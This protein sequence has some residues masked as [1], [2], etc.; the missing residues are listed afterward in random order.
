MAVIVPDSVFLEM[1]RERSLEGWCHSFIS[2][3]CDEN[4][5]ESNLT[6]KEFVRLAL[7]G[8]S[9]SLQGS[10]SARA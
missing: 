8:Y 4:P 9:P 10:T 1:V 5:D 3:G 7:P 6:G 2:R